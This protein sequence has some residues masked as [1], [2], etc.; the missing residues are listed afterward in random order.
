[1]LQKQTA[2]NVVLVHRQPPVRAPKPVDE[3][4]YKIPPELINASKRVGRLSLFLFPF[5]PDPKLHF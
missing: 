1:M 4:L 3:D 2:D 5:R